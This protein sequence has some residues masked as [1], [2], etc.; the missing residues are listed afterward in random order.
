MRSA[1]HG[2]RQLRCVLALDLAQ[3]EC[4]WRDLTQTLG[5]LEAAMRKVSSSSSVSA[6]Q[7]YERVR[8][9]RWQQQLH[10]QHQQKDAV[11][12]SGAQQQQTAVGGGDGDDLLMSSLGGDSSSLSSLA[13]AS[14]APPMPAQYFPIPLVILGCKYDV[15]Q[16]FDPEI[17]KHVC[18]ALRSVAL[19]LGATGLQFVSTH[20]AA[21]MAALRE[22]LNE[23]A[24]RSVAA[25]S[26]TAASRRRTGQRPV[27]VDHN[28]ALNVPVGADSWTL[29][30]HMP[31]QAVAEVGVMLAAH[32]PQRAATKTDDANE[33]DG[34]D[35]D[36]DPA[37]DPNFREPA[38]DERRAQLDAESAERWRDAEVR[39]QFQSMSS[40]ASLAEMSSD[41]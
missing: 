36:L 37:T 10:A 32:I 28:E 4:L 2:L 8:A 11:V 31:K 26:R 9:R 16:N 25:L 18:R 21:Q 34:G 19:L 40:A 22:Q 3:P 24:F 6:P 30:G 29:I 1:R 17:K 14:N 7:E 5:R 39:Q 35:G 27:V 33:S 12:N 23:L 13:L 15:F 20:S 41:F 38:I